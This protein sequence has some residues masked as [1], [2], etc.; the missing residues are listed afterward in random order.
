MNMMTL[1]Y[2]E[3]FKSYKGT[4]DEFI[5]EIPKKDLGSVNITQLRTQCNRLR[6]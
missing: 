5:A 4:L 6:V 3:K 1:K 2:I